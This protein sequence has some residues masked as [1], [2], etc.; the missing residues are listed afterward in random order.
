MR[1][2][3]RIKKYVYLAV[4]TLLVLIS[5]GFSFE[6]YMES[7]RVTKELIDRVSAEWAAKIKIILNE[8]L[9]S[10]RSIRNIFAIGG[11]NRATATDLLTAHTA[12]SKLILGTFVA[13]EPNSFD[14]RDAQYRNYPAH[15]STGRFALYLARNLDKKIRPELAVGYETG[16]WYNL[17]K[18]TL[19]SH[20]MEPYTDT[21]QGNEL[22][23][24][25]FTL[26]IL[27]QNQF[28][29]VIGIDMGL[30][31][32]QD[33]F[34]MVRP[35]KENGYL[36]LISNKGIYIVNGLDSSLKNTSIE[37][38]EEGKTIFEKV[39]T[40]DGYIFEDNSYYH[41][42]LPVHLDG[43]SE[44]WFVE[45]TFPL[46]ELL[47]ESIKRLKYIILSSMILTFIG[48][49]IFNQLLN[50]LVYKPLKIA[51]DLSKTISEGNLRV[52]S[53]GKQDGEMGILIQ[54]IEKIGLNNSNLIDQIQKLNVQL[55]NTVKILQIT[56]ET[57]GK[58]S[59]KQSGSIKETSQSIHELSLSSSKIDSS[60]QNVDQ[61]LFKINRSIDELSASITA[62]NSKMQNLENLSKESTIKAKR[63]AEIVT[64]TSLAMNEIRRTTI[65]VS[66]FTR[67]IA[68]ISKKTNLLALNA[69]IEA[70]RAGE[71]GR[72]FAVVADEIAKL[73]VNTVSTVQSI[74]S[75]MEQSNKAVDNGIQEVEE[76][77]EIFSSINEKVVEVS[78]NSEEVS[79]QVD[80]SMISVNQIMASVTQLAQ[81]TSAILS[82]SSGQKKFSNEIKLAI[83]EIE[84]VTSSSNSQI[85]NLLD[86]ATELSLQTDKMREVTN[87]F[88][89]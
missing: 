11:I 54:A 87:N 72:G 18:R 7:R 45:I 35:Y 70:A 78:S 29:G 61:N 4:L 88:K 23:M 15:D 10:I 48:I 46:S 1:I 8:E 71:S 30:D 43:I 65:E 77:R 64:R 39:M 9:S 27:I 6:F 69:A 81:L 84:V 13:Y 68:D 80:A 34:G 66:K 14:G 5:S 28:V 42:F 52:Q 19:A 47:I 51:I 53:K 3:S 2:G 21:V 89:V 62:I 17:P 44:R 74:S 83:G 76:S 58:V 24:T 82:S 57:F 67:V 36:N 86:V 16:E 50:S 55:I 20:L 49:I 59:N 56:A 22:L 33:Q 12:Q 31:F 37:A 79:L 32:L 75:L 63:G 26:P 85:Q 60:I 40:Q 73:A 38:T 41:V 25:S